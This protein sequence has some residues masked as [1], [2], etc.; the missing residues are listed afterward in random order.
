MSHESHRRVNRRTAAAGAEPRTQGL[1][2]APEKSS[3]R[4][5]LTTALGALLGIAAAALPGEEADVPPAPQAAERQLPKAM[6]S[7]MQELPRLRVGAR[8]GDLIGS[9]NRALQ[10]AVD[11]IA[12]LG[13]GTVE[14]G[15]GV[16]LMRDSLH[17]RS[18]VK[19]RGQGEKTVLLKAPSA[20]SDLVLDGDY[21]EEQ[22]T[23][24]DASG[25]EVGDGVAIWDQDAGGFHTTV[26][27]ITG[28][29]GNT[30]SLSAPLQADC[31]VSR[32][33]KA[34]TVFPVVSGCHLEGAHLEN[35][36]IDG[37]AE[38][39]APLN[40]CRGA[41]IFLYRAFGA[42]I[43]N[44]S[45]RNYNG[46]GISFQQSN[47]VEVLDCRSDNNRQ[48]GLHPGSGSQRPVVRGCVASGNGADGLFLC[49]RVRHGV[50]EDNQLLNNGRYGISIGHKDS[51][52]LL[53]RNV[54]RENRD[55]GVCFR[56]ES[57]GMAAHRNRL[58]ENL[59]EN[60]GAAGAAAI[61]IG[62]ATDGIVIR[63]NTIRDS[64]E[65]DARKGSCA[66][67]IGSKAGGVHIENN[68]V[69]GLEEVDDRRGAKE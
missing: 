16:Y 63:G 69:E 44:C 56:D 62:G 19:V 41:G 46:D 68:R 65:A 48:L 4:A 34:A 22:V 66:I 9:D 61:H 47:D 28:K 32:G 58:E 50:F 64:R 37:A 15:D 49:W 3:R 38:K 6:H 27:R 25:F 42:V 39:N 59:I 31:M 60:N 35:L 1:P 43:R 29:R 30:F 7:R 2:A 23:V 67:R 24:A 51:D 20:L 8:E 18:H 33:A 36:S 11:Y 52:N 17:L 53:R 13:G 26:A 12:G 40:G 55:H 45:A 54:V 5:L 14:I 21:G 10:A 57:A